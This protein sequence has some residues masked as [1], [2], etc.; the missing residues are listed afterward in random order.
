MLHLAQGLLSVEGHD[1]VE[2]LVDERVEWRPR[3]YR[4]CDV[5]ALVEFFWIRVFL[6]DQRT[7]P[8]KGFVP[9]SS[10]GLIEEEVADSDE[11][12]GAV[13]VCQ[14]VRARAVE[15]ARPMD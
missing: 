15:V 8:G 14:G 9:F 2:H 10:P 6:D 3:E 1:P 11:A 5:G 12:I 7:E 13:D 4:S